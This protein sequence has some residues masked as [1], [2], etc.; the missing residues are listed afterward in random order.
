MKFP[1]VTKVAYS[2]CSVNEEENELVVKEVL[3]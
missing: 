1:S 3:E 2:T